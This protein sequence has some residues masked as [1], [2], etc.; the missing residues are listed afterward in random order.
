MLIAALLAAFAAPAAAADFNLDKA[1]TQA[2]FTVTHL[3]LSK[4]HGTIPLING[5]CQIAANNLPTNCQAT[6]DIKAVDSRDERRDASLRSEY[7]DTDKYPTMTFVEKSV[8]GTPQA[9]TM[10]GDLTLH[11]VTKPVTLTG[12]MTGS[13]NF[14]AGATHHIAYTASTKIDRRDYGITFAKML[15]NQLFAGY[16]VQIDIEADA[17]QKS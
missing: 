11:G 17:A 16:D 5:S 14:G 7:F 4:V 15:D 2:A 12:Q 3:A 1:H 8:S 13:G 9:F 6:F 10:V